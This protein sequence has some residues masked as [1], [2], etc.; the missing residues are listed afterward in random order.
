MGV[1]VGVVVVW[2]VVTETTWDYLAVWGVN[3]TA[4]AHLFVWALEEGSRCRHNPLTS[5]GLHFNPPRVHPP[6]VLRLRVII[7]LSAIIVTYCPSPY[8]TYDS[9]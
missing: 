8:S 3:S 6:V 2:L 9:I 7:I 4:P 5:V 1:V